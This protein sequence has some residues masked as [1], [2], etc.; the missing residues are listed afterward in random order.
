MPA[1]SQCDQ[2]RKPSDFQVRR[3]RFW[4]DIAIRHGPFD[5]LGRLGFRSWPEFFFG[6]YR[7]KVICFAGPKGRNIFFTTESYKYRGFR[8]NF[9][10]NNGFRDSYVLNSGFNNKFRLTSDFC[11]KLI[12]TQ[13]RFSRQLHTARETTKQLHSQIN[14]L[15]RFSSQLHTQIDLICLCEHHSNIIKSCLV[16]VIG[17]SNCEKGYKVYIYQP[18]IITNGEPVWKWILTWRTGNKYN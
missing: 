9:M 1:K 11:H 17:Y 14:A 10:L 7:S 3:S 4:E 5:I 18:M 16:M 15:F 13:F 8:D 2:M 6:Q 12:H